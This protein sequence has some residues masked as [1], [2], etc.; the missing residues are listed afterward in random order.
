V[1]DEVSIAPETTISSSAPEPVQKEPVDL[2][3]GGIADGEVRAVELPPRAGSSNRLLLLLLLLVLL[4][5]GGF[6][7]LN[8]GL[9]ELA[10]STEGQI[11]MVPRSPPIKMPIE[12]G[13]EEVVLPQKSVAAAEPEPPME[14]TMVSEPHLVNPAE[15][16]STIEPPPVKSAEV[17]PTVPKKPLVLYSVQVGPFLNSADRDAAAKQLQQMGFSAVAG[18]GRGM[19]TMIR[20]LH[21]KYPVAEARQRLIELKKI[22]KSAFLL[23]AGKEMALY[24]GSFANQ[25][26]ASA[27]RVNLAKRGIKVEPVA[28]DLEMDGELL[29]A[30]TAELEAAQQAV[31]KITA[32]GFKTRLKKVERGTS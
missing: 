27:L 23:P 12:R 15:T 18:K 13:I 31:Q 28:R 30:L 8:S 7:L 21:G 22:V 4:L 20:L 1:T 10:P 14:K 19:V 29:L 25:E 2:A 11:A 26:R 24:A 16:V 3:G 32:A 6:F 9:I 17:L 5:A